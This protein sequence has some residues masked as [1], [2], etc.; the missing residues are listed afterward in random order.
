MT[1][2]GWDVTAMPCNRGCRDESVTHPLNEMWAGGRIER[3][4]RPAF[5]QSSARGRVLNAV[6]MLGGW[7]WRALTTPRRSREVL[8]VGTDPIL[9]VM[10]ALSWRFFRTRTRVAHWCH[11]LY[12]EAA[13]ADGLV[14]PNS[15]PLRVLT[16]LLRSANG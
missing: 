15:L 4:W 5:K 7:T 6:W 13:V 11:D 2:R 3:V 9:S 10:A 8:V 16:R 1:A 14:Q 12:P